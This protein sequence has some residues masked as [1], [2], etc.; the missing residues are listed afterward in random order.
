[1]MASTRCSAS[2]AGCSIFCPSLPAAEGRAAPFRFGVW[3]AREV[4]PIADEWQ[5]HVHLLIDLAGA[6]VDKLAKM[7]REGWGT[8]ARQV[9]V[10]M[11]ERRDHRAN[12][13]R[14]AHYM[15]KARFTRTVGNRREWLSIEDIVT[16]SC[17]PFQAAG[18]YI[19]CGG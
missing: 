2:I 3:G 12:I 13:I 1:M 7:L 16:L 6:D 15:T 8:G 11:L 19:P 4:E 5:F 17:S 14:C 18:T 9:Q 10:K